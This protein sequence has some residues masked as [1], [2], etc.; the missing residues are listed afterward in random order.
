LDTHTF[1]WWSSDDPSLSVPARNAI[2]DKNNE[3]F[4][5]SVC[6][7]E[8]AIKIALR[9]LTLAGPLDVLVRS[10]A[11][12]YQFKPLVVTYEHTYRVE[13]LPL[14]HTDP[15]DRLLIAQAMVENLV[16]IGRDGNFPLYGVSM[17]W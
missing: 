12:Q 13:T 8:M 4:L 3:I 17:L 10:H 16:I 1:I 14:H 2:A 15:F 6:T 9:K 5:S 11:E 7:W